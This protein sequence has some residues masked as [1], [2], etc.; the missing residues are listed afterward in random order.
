MVEL[1]AQAVDEHARRE[2]PT[3]VGEHLLVHPA[4]ARRGARHAA[5][6]GREHG[7]GVAAS[8]IGDAREQRAVVALVGIEA[9]EDLI[10]DLEQALA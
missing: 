3:T 4:V 6:P 9:V 8:R 1:V 10:E 7:L 5:R 2:T